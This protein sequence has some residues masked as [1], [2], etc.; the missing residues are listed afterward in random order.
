MTVSEKEIAS[1][2]SISEGIYEFHSALAI[3]TYCE[4]RQNVGYTREVAYLWC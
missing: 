4:Y 3:N 2:R 1:N